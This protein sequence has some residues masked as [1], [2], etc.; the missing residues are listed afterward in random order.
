MTAGGN[1]SLPEQESQHSGCSC[2][3][4]WP[5]SRQH[6]TQRCGYCSNCNYLRSASLSCVVDLRLADF[7]AA[8][9]VPAAYRAC[10][11]AVV[12]TAG[13]RGPQGPA[14]VTGDSANTQTAI[15]AHSSCHRDKWLGL[16]QAETGTHAVGTGCV[17]PL[18]APAGVPPITVA[19]AAVSTQ[20]QLLHM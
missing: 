15:A 10:A 3:A 1:P 18:W 12:M 16:M 6:L 5:I 9:T 2:H 20:Q 7:P 13:A 11:A 19:Q 17:Q 8:A 4:K 14:G